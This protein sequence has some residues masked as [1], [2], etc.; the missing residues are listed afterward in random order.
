MATFLGVFKRQLSNG[1]RL[2]SNETSPALGALTSITLRKTQFQV[3]SPTA[4]KATARKSCR[5][6]KRSRK[7]RV[8]WSLGMAVVFLGDHILLDNW[9]ESHARIVTALNR[10][11][12][13][14]SFVSFC[15][16]TLVIRFI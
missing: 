15:S 12:H 6:L 16:T 13:C 1:P 3:P 8:G 5:K 14:L 7:R 9:P 11:H 2:P 10:H 4:T